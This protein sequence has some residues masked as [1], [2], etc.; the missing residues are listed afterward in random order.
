[1][2]VLNRI[3]ADMSV[4]TVLQK[5]GRKTECLK[6]YFGLIADNKPLTPLTMHSL[7]LRLNLF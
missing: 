2:T 1:M 4:W 7:L 6:S 5:R 3:F